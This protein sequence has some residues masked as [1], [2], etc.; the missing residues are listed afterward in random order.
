VDGYVPPG[1][2]TG[3]VKP[4][5]LLL[6]PYMKDG[7]P[8]VLLDEMIVIYGES[9]SRIL[10]ELVEPLIRLAGRRSLGCQRVDEV[11]AVDQVRCFSRTRAFLPTLE[12]R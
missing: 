2:R 4:L 10:D 9:T 5:Q 3:V 6:C 8:A 11:A 12:R 7:N 1:K